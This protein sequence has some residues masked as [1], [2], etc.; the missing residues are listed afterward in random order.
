MRKILM[1]LKR[2]PVLAISLG[3]ALLSVLFVLPDAQYL[4][5]ID[6]DVLM[7]LFALMAVVAGLKGCG[8][9]DRL[10]AWLKKAAGDARRMALL[11]TLACFFLSMLITN[12]VA[13]LTFVP[14]TV[15]L[16]A[17]QPKTLAYVISLEAVAAN[18]GSMATPIGNPQNLYLF[19]HYD[20]TTADFAAAML[21]LTAA[22]LVLVILACLPVKR[23]AREVPMQLGDPASEGAEAIQAKPSVWRIALY[24]VQFIC[25]LLAV[26]KVVPKV[27]CFG[28]VLLSMLAFDRASLKKVDYALLGTFACFFIFVGNLGRVEAVRGLL[29][30]LIAGNELETGIVASQV[31]S[32]VPAALMLSGFTTDAAALMRGVDLGGL[33]TL[34]ASLASL[35]AFKLYM[36]APGAKAGRFLTVFTAMNLGFLIVLYALAKF[37]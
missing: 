18:L 5:Y 6:W 9:L 15:G 14:L 34:V 8:V 21:P 4:Q 11:L 26:F 17:A 32:N 2:E 19:A 24:A 25:C 3:L 7:L 22:S 33:G 27:V 29:T 28:L 23:L 10:S 20:M 1:F 16:M 37:V 30:S 13:L 12:D 35:I 36:K 31:L